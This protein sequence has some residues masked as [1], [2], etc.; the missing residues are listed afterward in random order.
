KLPRPVGNL[1]DPAFLA[2]H[3]NDDLKQEILKG[4]PSPTPP[5]V[6]PAS[7][8]LSGLQLDDI[9][10]FLRH[11]AL[12]VTDFFPHAQYFIAKSYPVDAKAQGRIQTLTGQSVPA[13]ETTVT[14]VTFY[15]DGSEKGPVFVP[16]DPVQLDKL[17]PKDRRGYLVFADLPQGKSGR[18]TTGIAMDRG[19]MIL[20]VHSEGG[21]AAPALDKAYQGYLGQGQKHEEEVLKVKG[22]RAPSPAEDK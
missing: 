16:Q 19:G 11:D 10:A 15:G 6:M 4:V 7:P 20:Q 13:S 12:Q 1:R 9:I 5:N 17:S 21:L 14:V 22:K 3:S 8:W 2:A 18:V